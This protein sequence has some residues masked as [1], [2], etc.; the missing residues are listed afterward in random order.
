[1]R[2]KVRKIDNSYIQRHVID[3]AIQY[4]ISQG[5]YIYTNQVKL[6]ATDSIVQKWMEK[7]K[8]GNNRGRSIA[9]SPPSFS[10]LYEQGNLALISPLSPS[11]TNKQHSPEYPILQYSLPTQDSC[12]NLQ[13]AIAMAIDEN[14][15]PMYFNRDPTPLFDYTDSKSKPSDLCP[16]NLFY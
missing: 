6:Y 4:G 11:A 12:T 13:D 14:D 3:E 5:D 15:G 9:I 10:S 8:E 2:N 7:V 16:P 1:M